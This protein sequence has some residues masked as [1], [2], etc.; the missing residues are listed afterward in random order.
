MP[1]C[2]ANRCN[3]LCIGSVCRGRGCCVHVQILRSIPGISCEKWQGDW[4]HQKKILRWGQRRDKCISGVLCLSSISRKRSYS[5][6]CFYTPILYASKAATVVVFMLMIKE[7]ENTFEFVKM[8]SDHRSLVGWAMCN[9]CEQGLP[10]WRAETGQN[11]PT[12]IRTNG[13]WGR[14]EFLL[15]LGKP[16]MQSLLRSIMCTNL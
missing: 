1:L 16:H 5:T 13:M 9:T 10:P 11:K 14:E 12:S 2:P 7:E 6:V 3:Y 8:A 15:G 4:G